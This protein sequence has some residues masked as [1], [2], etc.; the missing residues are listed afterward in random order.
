M[1]NCDAEASYADVCSDFHPTNMSLVAEKIIG[2]VLESKKCPHTIAGQLLDILVS[3]SVLLP[4]NMVEAASNILEFASD[5]EID[6]PKFWQY[7]GAIIAPVLASGKSLQMSFLLETTKICQE[8]TPEE[9]MKSNTYK[10]LFGVFEA[11]GKLD[12]VGIAKI[13]ELWKM[14][15]LQLNQFL[16][17]LET[18]EFISN[19]GLDFLAAQPESYIKIGLFPMLDDDKVKNDAVFSWIQENVPK[20]ELTSTAFIDTLTRVVTESQINGGQ[21]STCFES[22]INI[23]KRYINPPNLDLEIAALNALQH[24]MHKLEHPTKL[25]AT[26]FFELYQNDVINNDG[27]EA[28]RERKEPAE[29]KGMAIQ[30]TVKFFTYLQ[31]NDP[32]EEDEE[33]VGGEK[34]E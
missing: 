12:G 14:S 16:Q 21:L 3:K 32:E 27:F 9:G 4:Q 25:L 5:M 33:T 24:L 6:I 2:H 15:G 20:D 34:E 8:Q 28:W 17:P 10:Y 22:R 11:M 1:E 18:S 7:M 13:A 26:I 30:S 31:E 29:G 23:L 19:T